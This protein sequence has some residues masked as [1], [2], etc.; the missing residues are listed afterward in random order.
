MR[1]PSRSRNSQQCRMLRSVLQVKIILFLREKIQTEHKLKEFFHFF[2]RKSNERMEKIRNKVR[3]LI[4]YK[5]KEPSLMEFY[6]SK[7]WVNK[8]NTFAEPGPIDNSDFLCI[9]GGVHPSKVSIVDKLSTV[10]SQNVWEYLYATYV[11]WIL[12]L[13]VISK[14]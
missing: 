14:L 9:H 3:E 12:N 2:F 13:N 8:L 7:Q 5:N 10:L 11:S 6:V 1:Y 4:S